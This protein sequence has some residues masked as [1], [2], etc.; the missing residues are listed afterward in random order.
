MTDWYQIVDKARSL[1]DEI[2]AKLN[3]DQKERG[4]AMPK[5]KVRPVI[6]FKTYLKKMDKII[7]KKQPVP[8]TLIELLEEAAKYDV[9]ETR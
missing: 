6:S 7:K 2:D 5:K 9:K 8:D 1:I 3:R 4:G